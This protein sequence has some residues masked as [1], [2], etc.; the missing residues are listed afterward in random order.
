MKKL[1]LALAFLGLTAPAWAQSP[2]CPDRP[3]GDSTNACANTRFVINNA[4]SGGLPALPNGQFWIGNGSNVATA[5]TMSGSCTLSNTGVISC[6]AP[7]SGATVQ[8]FTTRAAAIAAT[9][10]AAIQLVI[11]D[12]YT[13][14]ADLGKNGLYLRTAAACVSAWMFA[15]ADGQCW[16]L[17]MEGATPGHFG[18]VGDGVTNDHAALQNWLTYCGTIK[19]PC[20]VPTATFNVTT[21]TQL[22]I[23]SD[24]V[25]IGDGPQA[26]IQRTANGAD[27]F[28][29]RSQTTSKITLK[30][31]VVR[32]VLS[33]ATVT[34]SNAS[35]GVV[36]WTG[37][38][39]SN[40]AA[41]WLTTTGTLPAPLVTTRPYFIVNATA[42][43]FNLSL[44]PGGAAINT[45][46]AGS[47]THS[48][49]SSGLSIGLTLQDNTDGLVEGVTVTGPWN[50]GIDN[51]NGVRNRYTGVQIRGAVNRGFYLA[52]AGSSADIS[53]ESSTIIGSDTVSSFGQLTAYGVNV[54]GFGT[55]SNQRFRIANNNIV[56]TWF[57]GIVVAD[58]VNGAV[59]TGNIMQNN[60]NSTSQGHAILIEIANTR[61]PNDV[62]VSNNYIAGGWGGITVTG[63]SVSY[64]SITGNIIVA[65][66]SD[67]ILVQNSASFVTISANVS[68]ANGGRGIAIINSSTRNIVIGNIAVANT[69]FGILSDGT[70]SLATFTGNQSILN[71]A[72]QY[73][74]LGVGD[75][76]TGNL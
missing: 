18:A 62:I 34:I 15:S 9:I 55:G 52:S 14:Y 46:T 4:G 3:T 53:L 61:S 65:A 23:S 29:L 70:T 43:T 13:T 48:L 36:T 76:A 57:D 44:T 74:T 69:G 17:S 41:V 35:P 31:F 75:V 10:D 22:N 19:V 7:A 63:A 26:I 20:R 47:G 25:I 68:R 51:V 71:T 1:L 60:A 8:S 6:G 12:G 72:G 38:N 49:G 39:Q 30:N 2:T 16:I 5:R 32:S 21:T 11:L 58:S 73:S 27:T 28:F 45:T 66:P 37:S 42:N 67:G 33:Y 56:D 24:T 59:V 54:N 50:I 40:T 64:I